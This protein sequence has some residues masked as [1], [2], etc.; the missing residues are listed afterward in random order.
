MSRIVLLVIILVIVIG[1]LF[2]LSTVPKE[3]PTRTIEVDVP[4]G[5]AAPGN[6]S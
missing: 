3:Q 5:A 4:Q 2:F 6:A 1:A